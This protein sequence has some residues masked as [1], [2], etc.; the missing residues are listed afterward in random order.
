MKN[1]TVD[2][3]EDRYSA[4][5]TYVKGLHKKF[6]DYY[7]LYRAYRERNKNVFSNLFIPHTFSTIE[8]IIPRI[9]S[10]IF[11]SEPPISISPRK[12]E[13]V[14]SSKVME[15]LVNWQ[16][17]HI[18]FQTKF[19]RTLKD[20]LIY[21]TGF[22]K[23]MWITKEYTHLEEIVTEYDGPEYSYVSPFGFYP[24]PYASDINDCEYV[25]EKYFVTKHRLEQWE[26]QG[27]VGKDAGGLSIKSI[28]ESSYGE[29]N[30]EKFNRISAVSG[31]CKPGHSDTREFI[32]IKEYWEPNRVIMVANDKYIIRNEENPFAN[33]RIP[34]FSF[35]D[36]TI[37]DEFY[38][39]GEVEIIEDLQEEINTQRNQ[40]IDARSISLNPI[41]QIAP[42]A[43]I[44]ED[45]IIF[46]PGRIWHVDPGSVQPFAVPDT[47]VSS[48][49]EEMLAT[50]NMKETTS[51]TDII[52]G[53]ATANTPDTATGVSR[54]D[55]NA[56]TRFNL[57]VR[58]YDEP[59][60]EVIRHFVSM[61][62]QNI[63]EEQVL[64]LTG[65]LW[66]N[67]PESMEL[68]EAGPYKFLT[69][70]P[71][72]ITGN[73]D[74]QVKGAKS[75]NQLQQQQ[76]YIQIL[77]I[78]SQFPTEINI[79]EIIRRLLESLE[80]VDIHEIL[81]VRQDQMERLMMAQ[82]MQNM[83]R[84]RPAEEVP[85]EQTRE[86]NVGNIPRGAG[87]L[88]PEQANQELLS[89]IAGATEGGIR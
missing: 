57:K 71:Q 38:G 21:G 79:R 5:E 1:K 89:Q 81:T 55:V 84:G 6:D 88:T 10:G 47:G 42:G 46:E 37:G 50:N 12:P 48:V 83:K 34:Y 51:V 27:I 23:S 49:E 68:N 60:R 77:Q 44:D 85:D 25:I 61:N 53:Q 17:K 76:K 13:E 22:G 24:D 80:V 64:R 39:I 7:K 62:Q 72:D 30:K 63:M 86:A 28:K 69:I 11:G 73:F 16:L 3:V 41:I 8:Q 31:L 36:H 70:R 9:I 40:R 82:E 45:D 14:E 4:S 59:I 26:A 33:K 18:N 58:N 19:E 56:S 15:T 52:R 35:R 32:E 2:F 78:V 66:K 67:I 29:V 54:L 65:D 87:S 43:M 20:S 74:Y 75:V